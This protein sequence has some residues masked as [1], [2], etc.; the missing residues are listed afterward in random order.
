MGG[1]VCILAA[2]LLLGQQAEQTLKKRC[3]FL[4]ELCE[5]LS[6]L[7]KEMT[8]HRT[9]VQ[10]AFCSAAKGCGTELGALLL[11]AS[12]RIGSRDGAAFRQ[13]W[14]E[15]AAHTVPPRL[16]N[17]EAEAALLECASALCC[18]DPVMQGTLLKRYAERFAVL[19][20]GAQEEYREKH[21]LYR[22]LS[23]AAGIFL[24]ILLI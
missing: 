22:R 18:T 12:D 24:V 3:R 20:K 15:A 14:Q 8:F 10:E 19:S 17:E 11:A 21:L 2:C 1:A 5:T 7:E 13:I 4:R 16:L 9:A 23:A 6:F